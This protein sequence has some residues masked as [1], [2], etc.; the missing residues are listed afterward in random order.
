MESLDKVIGILKKGGIGVMPTDTILGL[1]GSALNEKTV[2]KMYEVRKRKPDK[3]FI[4]LIHSIED[5][6]LFGIKPESD[7]LEILNKYWPG[8]V[9]IIMPIIQ[10]KKKDLDSRLH[11]NDNTGGK[12]EYLH[13]G[14]NSL[15]FRVPKCKWL[16]DLLK[17]TGPLAAP[18]ANPEGLPPAGNITEARKYFGEQVDFYLAGRKYEGKPST[19]IRIKDGKIEV[20]RE[21]AVEIS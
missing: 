17:E 10:D 8:K 3:P 18:S 4:T 19:L 5:L 15:A 2:E 7:T 1:V 21:G 16:R 13:R 11:G 6:K 12:F 20:I 9:S 14:T